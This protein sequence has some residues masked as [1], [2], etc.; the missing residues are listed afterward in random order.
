[1]RTRSITASW[2]GF[3]HGL[4]PP[5]KQHEQLDR[6]LLRQGIYQVVCL[7]APYLRGDAAS[8]LAD[9]KMRYSSGDTLSVLFEAASPVNTSRTA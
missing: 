1:M 3:V 6:T 7:E 9:I 2:T 8:H 5:E 4:V